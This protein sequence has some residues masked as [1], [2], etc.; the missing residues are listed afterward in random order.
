MARRR[1]KSLPPAAWIDWT[2]AVAALFA[3]L[4]QFVADL[5]PPAR[6]RVFYGHTHLTFLA[7]FT[8]DGLTANL[9][10]KVARRPQ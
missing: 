4:S 8:G 6:V 10:V 7:K 5:A 9:K 1:K 3:D 2:P